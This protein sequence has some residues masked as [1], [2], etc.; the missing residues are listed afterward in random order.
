MSLIEL[1]VAVAISGI[2]LVSLGASLSEQM[3]LATKSQKQ[4]LAVQL[5]RQMVERVRATPFD[6][7]PMAGITKE[8]RVAS[9]DLND[10][11]VYD[12]LVPILYRPL[13]VDA[14]NF[15]WRSPDSSNP[16][17]ISKFPGKV[18]LTMGTAASGPYG[19]IPNTKTATVLVTWSEDMP[20]QFEL[21]F[22]ICKQ[23]IQSE[24]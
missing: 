14:V 15:S 11:G 5:A 9:G 20:K 12:S 10:S 1:M 3:R 13:Q 18:Y 23:G 6:D 8:V 22:V 19:P 16:M 21:K 24:R 17:P 7:L 4:L 2:V